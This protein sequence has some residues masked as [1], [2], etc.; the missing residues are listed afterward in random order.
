M[1]Y[2]YDT[3][4]AL[5]VF[6][7]LFANNG[8]TDAIN[9]IFMAPK[10][11]A[12]LT[13]DPQAVPWEVLQSNSPNQYDLSFTKQQTINGYTPKNNKLLCYPY[14]YLLL[15]NNIGQNA[16][17]HYEKF[18]TQICNFTVKGVLSPRLRN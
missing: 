18:S 15:S 4:F 12:P 14:N 3:P 8:K 17:L 7:E 1:Y 5:D 13:D 9:C 6:L 11:L 10:W 2:R 16:I